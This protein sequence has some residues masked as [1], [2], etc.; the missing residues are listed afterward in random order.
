M[1]SVICFSKNR[2][3]QAKEYLRTALQFLKGDVRIAVLYACDPPFEDRYQRLASMFPQVWLVRENNFEEQVC[4]LIASAGDSIMFGVDDAF[5]Y[6]DFDTQEA[7]SLLAGTPTVFGYHA[8]MHPGLIRCQ[9]FGN[10]PQRIP[11]LVS[12]QNSLVFDRFTGTFDWNYPWEIIATVYRKSDVLKLLGT[13]RRLKMPLNTPNHF[14]GEPAKLF[15]SRHPV[16]HQ[17]G[18]WMAC[19]KR[20]TVSV[21]TVN[22]VQ[23]DQTPLFASPYSSAESLNTLF[24]IEAELDE[25]HYRRMRFE[26]V[27]VGDFVLKQ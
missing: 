18:S 13:C 7:I 4:S 5:W 22:C 21:I 20:P 16:S 17:F 12:H 8:K 25:A 27:H 11:G 1:L 6:D 23:A 14:E 10:V 3:F 26:S 19:V 9:T 2:P 15:M 24:D